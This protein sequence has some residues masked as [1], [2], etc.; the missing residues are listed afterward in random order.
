MISFNDDTRTLTCSSYNSLGQYSILGAI[1][2]VFLSKKIKMENFIKEM[3]ITNI[4]VYVS[5][6]YEM[7]QKEFIKDFIKD[8]IVSLKEIG[9]IVDKISFIFSKI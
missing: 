5:D 7:N 4:E 2:A 8:D 6:F 1:F 9:I 3:H